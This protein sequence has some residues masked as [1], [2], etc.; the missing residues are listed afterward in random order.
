M[1]HIHPIWHAFCR[2][3]NK[4]TFTMR[5][6]PF[7]RTAGLLALL[8]TLLP[9]YGQRQG[10]R[11]GFFQPQRPGALEFTGTALVSTDGDTGDL[12]VHPGVELTWIGRA[13]GP[14]HT[15]LR[16]GLGHLDRQ[17]TSPD[18][19]AD[20]AVEEIRTRLMLPE[21]SSVVR[22]DPLNGSFRPFFEGELGL[23]ATL[24]DERA[25]DADGQRAAY[26]IPAYDATAHYGWAAGV[27]VRMGQG[28]FLSMQYGKRFG[29][30]LDLLQP[31]DGAGSQP[32]QLDGE[33]H[34]ASV[35]L[36]FSL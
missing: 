33:R 12:L 29:G 9:A 23:A 6:T 31:S 30:T 13:P 11:N 35:G 16:L 19:D 4:P 5:H 3:K 36:S 14:L 10:G 32:M 21:I 15:G 24:L 1:G 8:I 22:L 28:A 2:F 17:A 34:R 25:F 26:R 20:E 18:M 27:R 7:L